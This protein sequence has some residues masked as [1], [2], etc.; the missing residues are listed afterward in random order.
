VAALALLLALVVLAFAPWAQIPAPT[1]ALLP[2][3]IGAPEL[4]AWL[5]VLALLATLLSAIALRRPGRHRK[6]RRLALALSLIAAAFPAYVLSQIPAALRRIDAEWQRAFGTSPT[7]ITP[8]DQATKESEFAP[9]SSGLRPHPFTWREMLFGLRLPPVR[10]TRSVPLRRVGGVELTADVYR[11][12]HDAIVPTVVQLYGGGW[13]GGDPGDNSDVA[14]ALAASGFAV[15]AIDYRHAPYW[16][17][18]SQLEDVLDGLR[19]VAAHAAEYGADSTRMALLGRSAGAQLAM[20]ASQDTAAPPIR[21]VVT[22]YGPV[23]LAEGYR[24]PPTPDPLNVPFLIAQFLDGTPDQRPHAYADAS[25]I[26]RASQPHPPVLVITGNRD[27]IVEPRFGPMLHHKLVENGTSVFLNMP[28]ADHAFDFVS[29][30]P[31]SQIALYYTQRFLAET[32]R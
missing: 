29:F 31:S 25:P 2:L 3:S 23:D 12:A 20:R 28:W 17:W 30:G 26:T 32:V 11:P 8:V 13:R 9:N 24:S 21:A 27:H 7:A 22:I 5:L 4:S 1:Q 6:L 10:I 18:P 14:Q 15:F 16:T 19:W